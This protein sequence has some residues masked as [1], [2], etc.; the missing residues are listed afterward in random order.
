MIICVQ[1][2]PEQVLMV[3][4]KELEIICLTTS[5]D[6]LKSNITN[7]MVTTVYL[8]Q[9]PTVGGNHYVNYVGWHSYSDG[10]IM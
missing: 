10:S 7:N 5:W 1:T 8:Q 4:H 9:N 6:T 2:I 3:M